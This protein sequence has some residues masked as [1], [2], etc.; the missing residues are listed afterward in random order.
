MQAII[1]AKIARGTITIAAAMRYLKIIGWPMNGF[2]YHVY[3]MP[4]TW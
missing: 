2:W 3:S 4:T 1:P